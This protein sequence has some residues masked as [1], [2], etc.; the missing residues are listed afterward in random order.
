[1]LGPHT[2]SCTPGLSAE[3]LSTR[4]ENRAEIAPETRLGLSWSRVDSEGKPPPVPVR[5]RREQGVRRRHPRERGNPRSLTRSLPVD[6]GRRRLAII[7]MANSNGRPA[8]CAYALTTELHNLTPPA[9]CPSLLACSLAPLP[10]KQCISTIR[11]PMGLPAYQLPV[12]P[13][14][15]CS[16]HRR[17]SSSFLSPKTFWRLVI[18]APQLYFEISLQHTSS[19]EAKG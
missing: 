19:F 8:L 14:P 2:S 5:M 15:R 18:K 1:M 9:P 12:H 13:T 6:V 3:H 11:A 4:G 17:N 7:I 16:S 10:G